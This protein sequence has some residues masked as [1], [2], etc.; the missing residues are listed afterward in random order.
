MP[1]KLKPIA[2]DIDLS[3]FDLSQTAPCDDRL[4]TRLT[5]DDY[6]W[7]QYTFET[8]FPTREQGFLYVKVEYIGSTISTMFVEQD[9]KYIHEV[10]FDSDLFKNFNQKFLTEHLKQWDTHAYAFCGEQLAV[11]FF[12]EILEKNQG[13]KITLK[14]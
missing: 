9:K 14:E 6:D 7:M 4:M 11:E 1:E 5:L 12:N 2:Y 10:L 3:A 13:Y 8:W